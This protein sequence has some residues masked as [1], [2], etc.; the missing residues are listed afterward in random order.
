MSEILEN[1]QML[2][3]NEYPGRGIIQGLSPDAENA[4][5]L[6]WLMGRSEG[7]RN[8]VI[9][10]VADAVWTAPF[11]KVPGE[12]HSLTIYN[13][14][15]GASVRETS[16]GH[17]ADF[18]I[19]SN[20]HQTDPVFE[21]VS[22]QQYLVER[23]SAFGKAL[24]DW[25]YEPDK[26]NFTPRISVM[27]YSQGAFTASM[28]SIVKRASEYGEI[29]RSIHAVNLIEQHYEKGIVGAGSCVHTYDRDGDPIPS[30]SGDPYTVGLEQTAQENAEKYAEILAG[31]NFVS[32]V[33][34]A[35]PLDGSQPTFHIINKNQK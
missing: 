32:I 4:I 15:R 34:K 29:G 22:Q 18:H 10:G 9:E 12:D 20:G 17:D 1:E 13:A 33:A 24:L 19:V 27:I 30:F 8:R 5:Q 16:E 14:M 7:S 35:I 31:D 23:V 3:A 11:E 25:A 21:K 28:L 6:Y 2:A 26:P